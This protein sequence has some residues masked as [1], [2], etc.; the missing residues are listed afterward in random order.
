M[1]VLYNIHQGCTT[2]IDIS[3]QIIYDLLTIS[4]HLFITTV[5]MSI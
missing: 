4:Q 1:I 5:R 3:Q 2:F